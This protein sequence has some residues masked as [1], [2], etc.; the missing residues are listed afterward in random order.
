[1]SS[2]GR[3]AEI[4]EVQVAEQAVQNL[5]VR[6]EVEPFDVQRAAVAGGHQHRDAPGAR[7]LANKHLGVERIAFLDEDV[8]T[9]EEPVDRPAS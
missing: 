8:D 3:P 9:V 2:L 1:M 7:D 5:P 6:L 4:R